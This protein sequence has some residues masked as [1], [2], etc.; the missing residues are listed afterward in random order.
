MSVS[1]LEYLVDCYLRQNYSEK[2]EAELM[3]LLLNAEN[4]LQFQKLIDEVI[5]KTGTEVQMP[6]YVAA[7]ILKS[8]IQSNTQ[9][10]TSFN[11][12]NVFVRNWIKVASAACVILFLQ[13][14]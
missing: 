7:S 13:N 3:S 11:N 9:N 12:K 10:E 1:R 4:K 5:E 2:E 6:D 14:Q 8:I